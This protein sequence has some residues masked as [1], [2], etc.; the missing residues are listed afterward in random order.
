MNVGELRHEIDV[1]AKTGAVVRHEKE[2]GRATDPARN[3]RTGSHGREDSDRRPSKE[4]VRE[5]SGDFG[6]DFYD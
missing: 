4:E 1:D 5:R 3:D 6:R 2:T